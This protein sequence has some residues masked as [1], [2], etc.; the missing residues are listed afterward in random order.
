[1]TQVA[2]AQSPKVRGREDRPAERDGLRFGP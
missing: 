2:M 1:M